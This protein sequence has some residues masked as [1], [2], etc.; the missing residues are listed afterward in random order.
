VA[1]LVEQG[2]DP[3]RILLLTFTR[4]AAQEML[5]RVEGMLGPRAGRFPGDLPRPGLQNAA[6][7]RQRH[8]PVRPLTSWTGR[9]LDVAGRLAKSLGW[10]IKGRCRVK[11]ISWS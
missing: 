5:L 8:R 10:I 11:K 9:R 6:P 1:W 4:K 7:L 3:G 2:V